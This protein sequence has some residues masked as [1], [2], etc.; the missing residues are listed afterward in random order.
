[1]NTRHLAAA[2]FAFS[3]PLQVSAETSA[4]PENVVVIE[5][6]DYQFMPAEL[7]IASGTTVRWENHER[8][9]FH[10]VYFE[11][12]GDEPRDYFWPGEYRERTFDEVGT[13]EY[14]CEPHNSSHAMRGVIHVKE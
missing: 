8:R 6:R 11:Q 9:Q 7:T 4:A 14:I 5:I 1:M 10:N 2:I 12:L 13:F 3:I